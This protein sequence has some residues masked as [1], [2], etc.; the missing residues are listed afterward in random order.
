[1]RFKL[2]LIIT[3]FCV[4]G[5]SVLGPE[6]IIVEDFEYQTAVAEIGNV[7][8]YQGN[9][10]GQDVF[11]E[12]T[13]WLVL[14][15]LYAVAEIFTIAFQEQVDSYQ[16][17]SIRVATGLEMSV[18]NEK[19]SLGETDEAGY[20]MIN[21][22][23]LKT[24]SQLALSPDG[25]IDFTNLISDL[26]ST[27]D[28]EVRFDIEF[29]NFQIASADS[30]FFNHDI[31][32][33]DGFIKGHFAFTLDLTSGTI[34][35]GMIRDMV[36][37]GD[38][39]TK[40]Y[41]SPDYYVN[42]FKGEQFFY[43]LFHQTGDFALDVA[44]DG[45][46]LFGASFD[47]LNRDGNREGAKVVCENRLKPTPMS[48]PVVISEVIREIFTPEGGLTPQYLSAETDDRLLEFFSTEI[49]GKYLYQDTSPNWFTHRLSLFDNSNT[50]TWEE[51][52]NLPELLPFYFGFGL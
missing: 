48:Q 1:M 40:Y 11:E 10:I 44:M 25:S 14:Q 24:T 7:A 5:C 22:L 8:E 23:Y 46:V 19:C 51:E 35:G 31:S 4:A 21:G 45:H 43:D 13:G 33:R 12:R 6:N 52:V 17:R 29:N 20:A 16:S 15:P 34:D 27:V 49:I 32:F 50:P 28:L 36:N 47:Y 42:R 38:Y 39:T 30:V 26:G 2:F 41:Y 37:S 3:A 9:A 18:V